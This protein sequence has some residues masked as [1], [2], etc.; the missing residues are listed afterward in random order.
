MRKV[1]IWV[2]LIFL[3]TG[4]SSDLR[5]Q[6]GTS[7]PLPDPSIDVVP[8]NA[9]LEDTLIRVCSATP[10]ATLQIFNASTTIPDNQSYTIDWGDGS[11]ENHDNTS[12]PNSSFLSH[13]YNGYGYYNLQVTVTGSNGCTATKDYLF[14]NGSNPSVGLANPG[15]TVGLCAPATIDFP[16]TNTGNNPA[17]TDYFIYIGGQL[18]QSYTQANVPPV[19]TYTFLDPSCGLSTS[20]GNYQNA[21]D[22]QIVASNPCRSVSW[23]TTIVIASTPIVQLQPAPDFCERATLNFDASN[24]TI[25]PNGGNISHYQ[26]EFPG[27]SPPISNTPFPT[28][29]QYN[30]PGTYTYTLRVDNQCGSQIVRDTFVIQEPG[31]L[32]LAPDR[33]RCQDQA[34]FQL[35]ASPGGGV[36][37]G[38]GVSPSGWFEPTVGT[39]G[40][41][42]LVY[43][44]LDSGCD[45]VDSMQVTVYPNPVVVAGESQA[46]CADDEP[47]ILTGESPLGGVWTASGGGVIDATDAFDPQAS[48]VGVFTLTYTY[49]DANG[50]E[51]QDDK[52]M[53]V[54]ELPEVEAGPS[55]SFCFLPNDIQLT[56]FTPAGGTWTGQGVTPS[57]VFSPITTPGPGGYTLYYTYI[58]PTTGCEGIDSLDISVIEAQAID[59]GPVD[60]L[61][62]DEGPIQLSGFSPA[63]GTWSGPGIVDSLLGIFDPAISGGGSHL[64]TYTYGTGS[65]KVRDPKVVVVI[66]LSDLTIGAP[67]SYC[68]N[69]ELVQLVAD[70]PAGGA[71]SGPGIIDPVAGI[72]DPAL[73]AAGVHTVRYTYVDPALA[74]TASASKEI[75]VV[76]VDPADFEIPTVAC[77]LTTISFV[78][79]SNPSYESFWDFGDGSTSIATN[80]IHLY[81]QPGTYVVSLVVRN[82]F[83]CT[84]TLRQDLFLTQAPEPVFSL[85]TQRG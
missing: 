6:C 73:A 43:S 76:G 18:I 52:T 83:G 15:N 26:W 41:N 25:A 77:E 75:T 36:W 31:V 3:A 40:T 70:G 82:P 8:G 38:T 69:H 80:P 49:V 14:Y 46:A 23:D 81:D 11:V 10:Q 54:Y 55:Q 85:D 48:G 9:I 17:G 68:I 44:F 12:F 20:T 58:N 74:C 35:N 63:N 59:A 50:C 42:T 19:F 45:L 78:N 29:I 24:L 79:H 28:G 53:V 65:C 51:D 30:S 37:T 32:T 84:D 7:L 39:L 47:V 16:I 72:F 22:V 2:V 5:A 34:G 67:E 27:A 64:L 21:F 71:W 13:L 60:S 4:S 66:D 33:E 57:G 62:L 61:C 1:Y 56:G